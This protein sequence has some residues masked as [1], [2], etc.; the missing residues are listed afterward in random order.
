MAELLTLL[1]PNNASGCD[2][3][4][5]KGTHAPHPKELSVDGG[6]EQ[7]GIPKGSWGLGI[8]GIAHCSCNFPRL[9]HG[10][11]ARTGVWLQ[12]D[13]FQAIVCR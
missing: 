2:V 11:G 1:G 7:E 6:A 13:S 3:V 5:S 9:Q 12:T 10:A 4:Q 8:F